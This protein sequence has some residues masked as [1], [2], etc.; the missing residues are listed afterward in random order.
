[1]MESDAVVEETDPIEEAWPNLTLPNL[2]LPNL[3]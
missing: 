2:T 1:M 3:T